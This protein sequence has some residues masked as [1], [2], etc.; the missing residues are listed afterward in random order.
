MLRDFPP[1]VWTS[2]SVL[3]LL[4]PVIVFFVY[5]ICFT[6]EEITSSINCELESAIYKLI[7][8]SLVDALH[9]WDFPA[10]LSKKQ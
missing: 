9:L 4:E 6:G 7:L 10:A 2:D 3:L 5:C 8:L 1:R